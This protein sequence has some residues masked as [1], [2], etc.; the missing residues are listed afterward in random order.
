VGKW[1]KACAGQAERSG[2]PANPPAMLILL[3]DEIQNRGYIDHIVVV[4]DM[5][6]KWRKSLKAD[7]IPVTDPQI[8]LTSLDPLLW[9][10]IREIA[11][12]AYLADDDPDTKA[13]H[14]REAEAYLRFIWRVRDFDEV[15]LSR[16]RDVRKR[17]DQSRKSQMERARTEN[18]VSVTYS[19][20]AL[21]SPYYTHL[22]WPKHG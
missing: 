7:S 9:V 13:F 20:Y 11:H 21:W 4:G 8:L 3:I 12:A 19:D 15:R 22:F 17:N 6:R 16:I 5:V 14:L 1:S 10:V 18:N 2:Y